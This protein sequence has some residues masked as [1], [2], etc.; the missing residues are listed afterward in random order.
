MLITLMAPGPCASYKAVVAHSASVRGRLRDAGA[1]RCRG[2]F[3]L[4]LCSVLD[5]TRGTQEG[6]CGAGEE[7]G[8]PSFLSVSCPFEDHPSDTT[9]PQHRKFLPRAATEHHYCPTHAETALLHPSLRDIS[10][11]TSLGLSPSG[12]CSRLRDI[13]SA[14]P[15]FQRLCFCNSKPFPSFSQPRRWSLLPAIASSWTLCH[16]QCTSV[17][18]AIPVN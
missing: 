15:T 8:T 5:S 6:D 12:V 9:A 13:S 18:S 4:S 7:K 1:T 14:R 11:S 10:I 3:C 2:R 16:P 17:Y